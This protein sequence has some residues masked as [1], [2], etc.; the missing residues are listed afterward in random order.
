MSSES[1]PGTPA[2]ADAVRHST[3]PARQLEPSR[4][5]LLERRLRRR[6]LQWVLRARALDRRPRLDPD[7]IIVGAQKAGSTSLYAYLAAHPDVDQ[8]LVKE[9]NY[10]DLLADRGHAW[11]R[12]HFPVRSDTRHISGEASPMYMVHPYA[13]ERIARDLPEVKVIAILREPVSRL[14]SHYRHS[15]RLGHETLALNEALR[16]EEERVA[17]DLEA[18]RRDPFHEARAFEKFTYLRR[19]LYAPQVARIQECF[20]GRSLFLRLENLTGTEELH[21]LCDFLGIRFD[22]NIPFQAHNVNRAVPTPAVELIDAV[23][24]ERLREDAN[25]TTEMLGWAPWTFPSR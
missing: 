8:P 14:V 24:L 20:P 17:R 23:S 25:L 1:V 2:S 11:Y 10:F 21:P 7:F 15:V 19:S 6:S 13:L 16:A 12:R 18:L 5:V 4:R 9:I 22:A 3:P